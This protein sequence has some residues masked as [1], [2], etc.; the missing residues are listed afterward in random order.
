MTARNWNLFILTVATAAL[1]AVPAWRAA[2][3]ELPSV[4]DAQT[5]T[6]V[7]AIRAFLN[8]LSTAQREKVQFP[9]TPRKTATAVK[10]SRSGMGGGPGGGGPHGVPGG[11]DDRRE[12]P[13]G[14]PGMG[15]AGGFVGEKYGEAVWSNYPVSDVPRPGL[16]LGS[17]TPPNAT[18]PCM[19]CRFC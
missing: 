13:G 10:F 4:T 8:S 17:L 2:T 12:G 1:C 15:P 19:R 9:F 14:G 16:R 6:V 11:P 7:A 3:A 18:Q 5:E